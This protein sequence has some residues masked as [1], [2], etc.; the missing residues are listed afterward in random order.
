[1]RVDPSKE[2]VN[3]RTD[4]YGVKHLEKISHEVAQGMRKRHEERGGVM[5]EVPLRD[6]RAVMEGMDGMEYD[7]ESEDEEKDDEDDDD[8]I[9]PPPTENARIPE[10]AKSFLDVELPKFAWFRPPAYL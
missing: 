7:E 2:A 8:S 6:G 4:V 3:I 1:M 5:R 10:G 9:P